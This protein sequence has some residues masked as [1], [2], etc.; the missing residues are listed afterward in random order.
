[1]KNDFDYI[2]TEKKRTLFGLP[3]SFTRYFLTERKFIIRTGFLNISETE[4]DIYRIIDKKLDM[5][6]S[7]RITGC[8]TVTINVRD[9]DT[10]ECVVKSIKNP[11]A[12][13]ELLDRQIEAQRDKYNIRGRDMMSPGA[14]H[15]HDADGDGIPDE[16][17]GDR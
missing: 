9:V 16:I 12:F 8:G 6:L 4:F 5:P 17:E 2:W 13:M 14:A 3:L 1:M 10:P 11:R 7:Q 15:F